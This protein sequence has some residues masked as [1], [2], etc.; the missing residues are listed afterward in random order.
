MK[1]EFTQK[2]YYADTDAYGVVW[3]GSYLRWMEVGRCRW[4]E[5]AGI[6]LIDLDKNHNIVIPVVGLNI[7]YKASAKLGDTVIIETTLEKFNALSAT[8]KQVIKSEVGKTFLE[9]HVETVAIN[10]EGK[11]YRRLPEVLAKSFASRGVAQ[12]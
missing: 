11:L 3:H 10:S 7:R 1:H 5:A 4:C 9:A 12:S 8:F 6:D 2:V